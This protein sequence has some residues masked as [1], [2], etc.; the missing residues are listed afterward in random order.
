MAIPVLVPLTPQAE[1]RGGVAYHIEGTLVPVLLLE[2]NGAPIYFD[3]YVFLWKEPTVQIGPKPN[4]HHFKRIRSGE[5]VFLVEAKGQGRIALGRNGAG[6]A[7]ALTLRAGEVVDVRE[8]QFIAATDNVAYGCANVKGPRT[9]LFGGEYF[10]VDVFTGQSADGVVWLHGYGDVFE[11]TLQAGEQLDVEP[12]GWIYKDH[13]VK[14]EVINQRLA[15]HRFKMGDHIA[16]H[17][18]TGPG[19]VAL[20]SMYLHQTVNIQEALQWAK[21]E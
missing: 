1:L 17:R 7:F 2:L 11:A 3:H 19:R 21:H 5:A 20:Q 9:I 8:H 16:W 12:G 14:L 10:V 13:T 15:E 18:L 4:T 6:R